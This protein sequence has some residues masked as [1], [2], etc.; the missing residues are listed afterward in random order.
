MSEDVD[1]SLKVELESIIKTSGTPYKEALTDMLQRLWNLYWQAPAGVCEDEDNYSHE[2]HEEYQERISVSD[3]KVQNLADEI[4]VAL[5]E[6][7]TDK[8]VDPTDRLDAV[9]LL[10]GR[11]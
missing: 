11:S 4:I 1:L 10:M 5:T 8:L 2:E 7:A 6:I 3:D 9:R